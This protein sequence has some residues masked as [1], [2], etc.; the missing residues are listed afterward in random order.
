[1]DDGNFADDRTNDGLIVRENSEG[2]GWLDGDGNQIF[3]SIDSMSSPDVQNEAS[4]EERWNMNFPPE[5]VEW[6]EAHGFELPEQGITQNELDSL[7]SQ[8]ETYRSSL[9]NETELDLIMLQQALSKYN[10]AIQTATG[11]LKTL[12]DTESSVVRN[13]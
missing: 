5:L 7:I 3:S 10:T 11:T 12:S 4:F 1:L 9:T 8:V 13:V 6:L 2:F